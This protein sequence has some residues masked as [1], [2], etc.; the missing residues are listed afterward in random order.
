MRPVSVI[1]ASAGKGKRFGSSKTF[2]E[3]FGYPLLYFTLIPFN[4]IESVDE[5]IL[6]V[7]SEDL[8]R[9][10]LLKKYFKKIKEVLTGGK[11]RGDTVKKGLQLVRNDYVLVHDGARPLVSK[12]LI[13]KVI[14]ALKDHPAVVPAISLR[15]TI[16]EREGDFVKGF[17]DRDRLVAVQTP[18]GFKRD[19]LEKAYNQAEIKKI[20][21]TDDSSLVE[22]ILGLKSL[23]VKGEEENIKVT[24]REDIDMIRKIIAKDM[25]IGFGY[26]IHRLGRGRKLI[27]GGVVISE[28]FGAV[29][30][31]DGDALT[32]SI[33]DALLGGTSLGDIGQHFP[34]TDPDLMGISSLSLLE[35]TSELLRERGIIVVNIDATVVL[36]KPKILPY[37]EEMKANISQVLNIDK[38]RISIKGKRGEG[39]DSV[40]K[41]ESIISYS[42]ALLLSLFR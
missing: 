8:E 41:G 18:Q 42:T 21:T 38:N 19:L 17:I 31:S 16:K 6:L 5:I 40:G 32:H 20:K 22:K 24:Y 29:G 3:L 33:I 12:N 2:F 13:E 27:V 10:T 36:E 34:D 9:G 30:H 35:R 7:S 25:R 15:D 14:Q 28:E 1:I 23:V 26:D 37:V 4:S 39:M 11:E